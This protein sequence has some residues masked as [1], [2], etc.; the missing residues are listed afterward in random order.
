MGRRRK[1]IGLQKEI[2]YWY[3]SFMEATYHM[4]RYYFASMWCTNKHPYDIFYM[5]NNIRF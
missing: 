3:G 1:Y 5:N 4:V 2:L